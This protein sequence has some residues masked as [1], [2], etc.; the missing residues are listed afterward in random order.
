MSMASTVDIPDT[1]CI[2]ESEKA[3]L[4]T[5]GDCRLEGESVWIPKSQVHDDS[6]VWKKGQAG[7][8]VVTEW[9]AEQKGLI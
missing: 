3:I 2:G 1:E 7:K 5:L 8:L 6:E 9:I 4:V